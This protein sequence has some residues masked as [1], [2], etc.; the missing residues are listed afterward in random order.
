MSNEYLNNVLNNMN[1]MSIQNSKYE[2][3]LKKKKNY[4]KKSKTSKLEKFFRKIYENNIIRRFFM[5]NKEE[6]LKIYRGVYYQIFHSLIVCSIL[7]IVCFVNDIW[8]LMIL[9]MILSMDSFCI[10]VLHN[11]PLTMLE[12]KYLGTSLFEEKIQFLDAVGIQY[13]ADHSYEKQ[14]ELVT[15]TV[16]MLVFKILVLIIV[17]YFGYNI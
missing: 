13:K 17:R 12:R 4:K 9:L 11:C 6:R 1:E 2:D 3:L 5:G 7:I 15:N 10:I 8:Y 14:L 16:C